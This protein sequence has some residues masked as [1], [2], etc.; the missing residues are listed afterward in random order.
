MLIRQPSQ[1]RL[2]TASITENKHALMNKR[3]S[4]VGQQPST[5]QSFFKEQT[6]S[7]NNTIKTLMKQTTTTANTAASVDL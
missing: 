7:S 2:K 6:A 5:T 3:F 4:V 1:S